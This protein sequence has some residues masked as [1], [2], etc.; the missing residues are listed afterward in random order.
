MNQS[1][2]DKVVLVVGGAGSIGAVSAK[3]FAELGA[4][5]AISHRDVPDEAA[6]AATVV[7]S[8]HGDGHA[9]LIADVAQTATL[10]AL[11]AEIERRFGRLDILV[12]AAGF[13][14][15]V[16][17]ADLD[18]LDDDLI[19]RMFAVNWRGQFA[20]IRTFAPLLKASGDGLVV[21]ISSIAGTNGIGSSIAYCAVKA[22]I[23][24]MTKSLARVLAPEVRVLAVAPGVVDTG[25]VP[26]RGADFNAKTAT[27]TPLKRIATAEDIA[28]AILACANQLGFATGTTFV[29]DGGR[30]L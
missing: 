6:A 12:N 29:V 15:P 3:R 17:H 14:K 28:S 22:G 25:F 11:R 2:K 19:D 10:K 26:G 1:V 7:Q 21:S 30:S 20:A 24:V 4:R 23:D 27:T 8:L 5:I 18:A 16:P 13:T 9:A